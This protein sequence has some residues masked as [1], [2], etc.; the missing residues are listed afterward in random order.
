MGCTQRP[1]GVWVFFGVWQ[2][3]GCPPAARHHL[4]C[5]VQL[6]LRHQSRARVGDGEEMPEAPHKRALVP[7]W[8]VDVEAEG[9]GGRF[10]H[11]GAELGTGSGS[12]GRWHRDTAPGLCLTIGMDFQRPRAPVVPSRS[13]A[14]VPPPCPQARVPF[15]YGITPQICGP[16]PNH[17]VPPQSWGA[18]LQL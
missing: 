6:P 16:L 15:T 7:S 10:G 3:R 2:R 17:W 11:F 8:G 5:P 14:A 4:P 12:W 9:D 18:P 1:Y 13:A